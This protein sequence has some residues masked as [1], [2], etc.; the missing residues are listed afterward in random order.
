[1]GSDR[2]VEVRE[3]ERFRD[4]IAGAW[5]GLEVME[6]WLAVGLLGVTVALFWP[7]LVWMGRE[8]AMHEQ[9]QHAFLVLLL[10]CAALLETEGRRM[11]VVLRMG[12][13]ATGYLTGSFGVLGVALVTGSGFL[14][15]VAGG[16]AVVAWIVFFAGPRAQG[17]GLGVL[18]V[19]VVYT[20]L[21]VVL[22]VLDW[23]MRLNAGQQTAWVLNWLGISN[24]LLLLEPEVPRLILVVGRH[25]FEVAAECNGFGLLASALLLALL[26]VIFRPMGWVD[27]FLLLAAAVF[28]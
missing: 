9:L 15:L 27:R 23:P 1:M 20:L 21:I 6:R 10:G 13:M 5:S 12:R 17:V 4:R 25:P 19:F 2:R 22:P 8:T 28:L 7:T 26:L 18:G 11:P 24:S 3:A 14:V 16:L